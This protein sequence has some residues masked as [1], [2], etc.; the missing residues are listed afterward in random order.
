MTNTTNHLSNAHLEPRAENRNGVYFPGTVREAEYLLMTEEN[1]P[2]R[3]TLTAEAHLAANMAG[4]RYADH[5]YSIIDLYN[6]SNDKEL[7][8]QN[9]RDGQRRVAESANRYRW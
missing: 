7:F 1:I 9:L 8:I 6:S 2:H 4:G 5:L 3:L